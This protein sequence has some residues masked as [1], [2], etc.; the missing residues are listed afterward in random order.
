[1]NNYQY[2]TSPRKIEYEEPKKKKKQVKSK[3]PKAKL[4]E[5]TIKEIEIKKAQRNFTL[6]MAIVLI[7]AGFIV[8]M[9]V[10]I[11]ESFSEVQSMTKTISSL[12]KE[13]SQISVNIQNSLNLSNIENKAITDSGMQ[14]LNNKQIIYV[15]LDTK[16]YVEI[17]SEKIATASNEGFFKSLW[18][19]FLNIF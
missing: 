17:S 14:K 8:F 18:N 3:K 2:E 1:M 16:D 12:E 7:C 11:N 4:S 9:N 10:K 15:A 6:I 13:N 19:K 5:K